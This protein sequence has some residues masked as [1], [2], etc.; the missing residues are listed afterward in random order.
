MKLYLVQHAQ[1]VAESVDSLTEKYLENGTLGEDELLRGIRAATLAYEYAMAL[2]VRLEQA[3]E[4]A[5]Q[6]IGSIQRQLPKGGT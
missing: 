3:V 5:K 6:R 2:G 1:A 4:K